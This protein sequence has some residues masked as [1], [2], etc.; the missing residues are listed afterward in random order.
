MKT[1]SKYI[2]VIGILA[3]ACT[4]SNAADVTTQK[5]NYPLTTCVVSGDDLQEMGHPV[6]YTYKQAGQPDRVVKFC[7]KNCIDDFK[8]DPQKYL[9]IIDDAAKKQKK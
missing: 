5:D 4:F 2:L 8:K 9:A 7:C 6:T 1:L 3:N